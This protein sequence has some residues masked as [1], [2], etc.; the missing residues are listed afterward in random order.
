MIDVIDMY[1][2][3]RM[4]ITEVSKATG[5]TLSTVRR[6]LLLAGVLRTKQ[7]GIALATSQGKYGVHMR[8]VK[9]NMTPEWCRNISIGKIRQHDKTARGWRVTSNGYIEYTR[10][11]LKG[12]LQHV[13]FME[14]HIGRLLEQHEC[15]HHIDRVRTNNDLSNLQ[16]MT[17]KDH[18][19]LHANENLGNRTRNQFGQFE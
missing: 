2:Q 12:K 17:K 3:K 15:V 10:G 7:A 13:H 8:G 5:I 11:E 14:M 18:A 16:L 4:S 9:K 19:K 6:K 1:V